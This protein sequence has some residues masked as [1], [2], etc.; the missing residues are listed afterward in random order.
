MKRTVMI[1]P[2]LTSVVAL[3]VKYFLPF[4]KLHAK[5]HPFTKVEDLFK[6]IGMLTRKMSFFSSKRR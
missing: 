1:R 3:S 2:T 4:T 6:E 5:E